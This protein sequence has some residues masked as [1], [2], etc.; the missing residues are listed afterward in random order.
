MSAPCAIT[1]RRVRLRDVL[2]RQLRGVEE[3]ERLVAG[4][5][6]TGVEVYVGRHVALLLVLHALG[7]VAVT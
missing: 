5:R 2:V 7:G 3:L 6:S 4:L 1:S